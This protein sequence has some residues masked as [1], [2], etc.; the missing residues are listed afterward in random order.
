MSIKK[1]YQQK[2]QAQLNEWNAEIDKLQARADQSTSNVKIEYYR[3]I[4]DLRAKQQAAQEKLH[5][6]RDAK[7]DAWED[8]KAGTEHAWTTLGE[9][10]SKAAARFQ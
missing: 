9:A 7:D 6:L 8:L 1:S 3:Q 4:E 10:I 2:L 5:E